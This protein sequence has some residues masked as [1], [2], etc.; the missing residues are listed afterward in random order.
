M[1]LKVTNNGQTPFTSKFDGQEYTFLP[2]EFCVIS[3]DAAQ[4]IFGVGIADK[5]E[6]LTRHGWL[7]HS[8]D[9]VNAMAKLDLFSFDLPNDNPDEEPVVELASLTQNVEDTTEQGSAPLQFGTDSPVNVPDGAVI[10]ESAPIS[11]SGNIL[12]SLKNFIKS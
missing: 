4:H 11:A 1:F 9:T 2:S 6:V 5:S 12:D 8:S 7:A 3:A 10:D